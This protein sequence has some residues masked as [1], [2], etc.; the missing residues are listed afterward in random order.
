[1][2]QS[3]GNGLYEYK[4]VRKH[5][6]Q[7][8]KEDKS[9]IREMFKKVDNWEIF[10]HVNDRIKEKNYRITVSDIV[11]I[12][13]KG[14]IIEYE[15]KYYVNTDKIS[16]LV[17]LQ[18]IRKHGKKESDIMHMVFDMTSGGIVSVWINDID[19]RHYTLDM[20]IYNKG[21]KVGENYWQK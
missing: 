7:M 20:G 14:S 13:N 15:Q 2:V 11:Q 9:K 3:G 17:V 1:M 4:K 6:S 8:K 21:L 16:E 5:I 18:T 10:D 19:D 12:I